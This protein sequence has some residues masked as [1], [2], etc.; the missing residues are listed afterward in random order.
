MLNNQNW[1]T[2]LILL[3]IYKSPWPVSGLSGWDWVASNIVWTNYTDMDTCLALHWRLPIRALRVLSSNTCVHVWSETMSREPDPSTILKA[4][5]PSIYNKADNAGMIKV[6]PTFI[7]Q[8]YLQSGT[9][10]AL[11][12]D[13]CLKDTSQLSRA[14]YNGSVSTSCATQVFNKPLTQI[15][16]TESTSDWPELFTSGQGS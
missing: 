11:Q 12:C 3:L 16:L 14:I 5:S 13:D 7:T 15:S 8:A 4:Y 6:N 10:T 1:F 2:G 9:W